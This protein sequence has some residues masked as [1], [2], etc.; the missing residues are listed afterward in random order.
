[1]EL[2]ESEVIKDHWKILLLLIDF[3]SA[4]GGGQI[5]KYSIPGYAESGTPV[6][7]KNFCRNLFLCHNSKA[8]EWDRFFYFFHD[9]ECVP[10]RDVLSM[11]VHCWINN[12]VI[13]PWLKKNLSWEINRLVVFFLFTAYAWLTIHSP[14]YSWPL[15]ENSQWWM[16]CVHV[17]FAALVFITHTQID[18][19]AWHT[20][21]H[22][23]AQMECKSQTQWGKEEREGEERSRWEGE[24][25]RDVIYN[26]ISNLEDLSDP[27]D[28]Q[29]IH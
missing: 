28:L 13:F 10:C 14:F 2:F 20:Q 5:A 24:G 22:T 16:D 23:C 1:M 12:A 9:T 27:W 25:M 7:V 26:E 19:L 17:S 15:S 21:V 29:G 6:Q 11:K 18:S 8:E 3:L 4:G